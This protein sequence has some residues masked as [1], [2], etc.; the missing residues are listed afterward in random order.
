M[1]ID[2][3]NMTYRFLRDKNDQCI[4]WC[5]F[6]EKTLE[7]TK[8]ALKELLSSSIQIKCLRHLNWD[9]YYYEDLMSK[10]YEDG[11]YLSVG[12]DMQGVFYHNMVRLYNN[13]HSY[14]LH[15]GNSGST[16]LTYKIQW[17]LRQYLEQKLAEAALSSKR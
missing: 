16:G 5:Y 11:F 8:G 12:G 7:R 14:G 9:I 13:T 10:A 2:H 3:F 4:G 17:A 15:K 1:I 6:P